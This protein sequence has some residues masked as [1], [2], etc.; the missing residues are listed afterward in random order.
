[1]IGF[2]WRTCKIWNLVRRVMMAPGRAIFATVRCNSFSRNDN[3]IPSCRMWFPHLILSTWDCS[4]WRRFEK[5]RRSFCFPMHSYEFVKHINDFAKVVARAFVTNAMS[6]TS[7]SSC[8]VSSILS[9]SYSYCVVSVQQI[10]KICI[11]YVVSCGN[12]GSGG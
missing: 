11:D 1:M 10:N 6:K 3:M 4:A 8:E 2:L 5:Y 12:K 7:C 9:M